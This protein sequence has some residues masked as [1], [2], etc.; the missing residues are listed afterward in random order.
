MSVLP[1]LTSERGLVGC[2]A[3]VTVL[4]DNLVPV[5]GRGGVGKPGQLIASV[6]HYQMH[7]TPC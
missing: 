6:A 7:G 5:V 3:G 1:Y 4:Q 2:A